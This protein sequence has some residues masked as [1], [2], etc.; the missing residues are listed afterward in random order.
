MCEPRQQTVKCAP[1]APPPEYPSDDT[2]KSDGTEQ[3]HFF[4]IALLTVLL[5]ANL[6]FS[7]LLSIYYF[8]M[9]SHIRPSST[10]PLPAAPKRPPPPA[11]PQRPPPFTAPERPPLAAPER[12]PPPS[13]PAAPERPPCAS[14]IRVPAFT[15]NILSTSQSPDPDRSGISSGLSDIPLD[16]ASNDTE[17]LTS[18]RPWSGASISFDM[19]LQHNG[20]NLVISIADQVVNHKKVT[21]QNFHGAQLEGGSHSIPPVRLSKFHCPICGVLVNGFYVFVNHVVEHS[22]GRNRVG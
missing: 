4:C 17:Y 10:P 18:H 14:E 11:A 6:I 9:V 13:L 19:Y 21:L 15:P 1:C 12:P 2:A 22:L 7:I 5:I 3:L 16:E 20:A 8:K